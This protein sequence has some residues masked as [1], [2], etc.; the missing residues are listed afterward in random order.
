MTKPDRVWSVC[1][2]IFNH[3]NLGDCIDELGNDAIL[4]VGRVVYFGD[5]IRPLAKHLIGADDVKETLEMRAWDIAGEW[6][7]DF[8]NCSPEAYKLLDNY[9]KRWVDKHCNI[10]FYTVKN[11]QQ[12]VITE[13]DI[14]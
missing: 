10:N 7:D 14:T 3:D 1:G 6:A 2:E 11:V 13:E 5:A 4:E 8:P 12:Y 9:L